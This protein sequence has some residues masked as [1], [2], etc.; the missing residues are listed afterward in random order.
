V[1]TAGTVMG[2]VVVAVALIGF[3]RLI[4]RSHH[5]RGRGTGVDPWRSS[6]G[7]GGFHGHDGGHGGGDGG[8]GGHGGGDGGH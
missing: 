8:D 1:E 5:Y 6:P 3:G 4:W 2:L 7:N